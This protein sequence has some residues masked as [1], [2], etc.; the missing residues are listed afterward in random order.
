MNFLKKINHR[1]YFTLFNIE[2]I[3]FEENCIENNRNFTRVRLLFET[4]AV[5]EKKEVLTEFDKQ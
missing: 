2:R 4:K 5:A 3:F 1:A